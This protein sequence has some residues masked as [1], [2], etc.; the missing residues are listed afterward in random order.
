MT[1]AEGEYVE[2]LEEDERNRNDR[3][4]QDSLE[5]EEQLRQWHL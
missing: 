1:E 2:E 3:E 4:H 5:G